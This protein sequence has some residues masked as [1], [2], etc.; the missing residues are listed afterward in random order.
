MKDQ[1]LVSRVRETIA[2]EGI[3][4]PDARVIV[5]LS[6]GADS[7]ALLRVLLELGY[8]CL[9]AHCNF[10]LRG[11]ESTRD[12]KFVQRLCAELDVDLAVTD[13]DVAA[14][15]RETG[16]SVEMACR[17]LRYE[18]FDG[19]LERERA[20]AI[21]VG[22]HREDNVETLLL[23][24]LRGTG[25]RGLCGMRH[26]NGYVVRPMLDCSRTDIEDYL[27]SKGADWVDDSSN[28]SCDYRRNRLRNNIIPAIEADFDGAV[29]AMTRTMAQVTDSMRLYDALVA[30]RAALYRDGSDILLGR[31]VEAE[32]QPRMLLFEMLRGEGFNMSVV[33]DIIAGSASS[34]LTFT[35][36]TGA[37]RELSR[38][39]LT[40]RDADTDAAA[41]PVSLRRDVLSP[42]HIT[43]ERLPVAR[44][45]P[46]R[47]PQ[48]AYFD[49][50][51]ADCDD[52]YI[53]PW[54]RGDR[55][56]PYGM[57]GSKLV[58]DLMGDAGYTAAQKRR[59]RLLCCGDEILWVIGLRAS[60]LH[61]VGPGTKEFL[62]LTLTG[63]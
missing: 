32:R 39:R 4:R 38:G 13:F 43:V 16:E 44:F 28:A 47:D 35:S 26:R 51:L 40:L 5:A 27:H 3:L 37:V 61:T 21:A 29:Q 46:E 57:D 8:D 55:I 1:N 62:R 22:H 52:L 7:V 34:G 15:R 49:A 24:M 53:R 48:V 42:V 63:F 19:L 50:R 2:R 60:S 10:H 41:V 14:R 59:V 45:K 23:N 20:Q 17:S 12:M 31:L 36:S 30:E 58:S 25:P 11:D 33:E 54:Q 18:W 6:G 9:A 56:R